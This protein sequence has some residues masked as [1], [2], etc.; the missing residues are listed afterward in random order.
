ML[1]YPFGLPGQPA[2][3]NG[4]EA[5]RGYFKD[6]KSKLA[7]CWSWKAS[8]PWSAGLDHPEVVVTE[9]IHDGW[10]KAWQRRPTCTPPWA[11]IRV[12]DGQIVHYDDY[13]NPIALASAARPHQ[14][15]LAAALAQP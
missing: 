13:M 14:T 6:R 10:S 5:I 2:E 1:T 4:R 12:R 3:L 11:V 9:I 15:P 7:T 8:K